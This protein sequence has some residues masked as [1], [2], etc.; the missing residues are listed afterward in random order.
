MRSLAANLRSGRPVALPTSSTDGD[1]SPPEVVLARRWDDL[2]NHG[3]WV[4]P[5][6]FSRAASVRGAL[7]HL[8]LDSFLRSCVGVP[9]AFVH[10]ARISL[11]VAELETIRAFDAEFQ[12]VL[13]ILSAGGSETSAVDAAWS[14]L[15]AIAADLTSKSLPNST[16]RKDL[17]RLRQRMLDSHSQLVPGMTVH[18]AKGHEWDGVG[19]I[20]SDADVTHLAAGLQQGIEDHRVIYVALTR[21]RSSTV[22]VIGRTDV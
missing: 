2:W 3:T 22:R 19:V 8:L 9:G 6:A 17:S 7:M 21:A 15:K 18:Q 16:P 14:G 11:G 12:G 20:L 10:E 1:G 13:R 4:T 5:L